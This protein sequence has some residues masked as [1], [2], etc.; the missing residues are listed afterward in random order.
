M[1]ILALGDCIVLHSVILRC[2]LIL[3]GDFDVRS[4][5]WFCVCPEFSSGWDKF[6]CNFFSL[7]I[8]ELCE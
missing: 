2:E 3:S 5:G 4:L 1:S 8:N 6:L 7:E